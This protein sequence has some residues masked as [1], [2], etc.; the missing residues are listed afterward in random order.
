[1]EFLYEKDLKEKMKNN[2]FI[3]GDELSDVR[4]LALSTG[5]IYINLSAEQW[6]ILDE[7]SLITELGKTIVHEIMHTVNMHENDEKMCQIMSGQI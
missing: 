6:K 1:M 5:E 4:G 3:Y 7:D 2:E